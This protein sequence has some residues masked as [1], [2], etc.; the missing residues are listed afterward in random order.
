VGLE[1]FPSDL[2]T[3]G[4]APRSFPAGFGPGGLGTGDSAPGESLPQRYG[5]GGLLC[6]L[7]PSGI[8]GGIPG[9][10]LPAS[11]GLGGLGAGGI[12]SVVWAP[13]V[14]LRWFGPAGPIVLDPAIPHPSGTPSS[15][16]GPP[17]N[18]HSPERP[19]WVFFFTQ[20]FH[21]A[22]NQQLFNMHQPPASYYAVPN[23]QCILLA[24]WG[25]RF[26]V[27]L[28]KNRRQKA[29]LES[30]E[31]KTIRPSVKKQYHAV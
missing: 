11:F 12:V 22:G 5:P 19:F 2:G 7:L 1:G 29:P 3:S 13:A 10:S 18:T 26:Q 14:S 17:P 30:G 15:I 31:F 8:P 28:M 20:P 9:G 25:I 6:S 24:S 21:D 23:V 4:I 16:V 27:F